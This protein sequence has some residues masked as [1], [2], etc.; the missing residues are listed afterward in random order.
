MQGR[1]RTRIVILTVMIALSAGPRAYAQLRLPQLPLPALPPRILPQPLDNLEQT[2]LTKVTELRRLR[3]RDLVRA[4]RDVVEINRD[5]D[6]VVRG[7]ILAL[8]SDASVLPRLQALGFSV[9]RRQPLAILD[10]EFIVL[11]VPPGWSTRKAIEKLRALDASG[12]F[13]YNHLYSGVG[14]DGPSAAAPS[15]PSVTP[16][17]APITDAP[18]RIGLLD[19]GI[20]TRHEA[21]R[22]SS[23]HA[24][25]CGG[26]SVP[27][28]HGTAVASILVGNSTVFHGVRPG[29]QLFA[30]DVYCGRPTGGAADVIVAAMAWMIQERVPVINVSLVGPRN[31]LL[32]IAVRRLI[33]RG[34]VVVA[35]VGNDGPAAP[36]L[37][38]AA[39]PHVVGVT[40]VDRRR[41]VLLEAG[42]GPQVMFAAPG[43][44]MSAAA[45][46]GGYAEVR[47]TSFAAPIVAALLAGCLKEPE[48]AAARDAVDALVRDALDLGA[49][50]KDFTYGNG[51]VGEAFWIDPHALPHR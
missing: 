27:D 51:L 1:P 44:Q 43:A 20:D 7:E 26:R 37:Y 41:H 33:Q 4:H 6:A 28:S 42:R 21:L 47:G 32:E 13:D 46:D 49:A 30:A 19:T 2:A 31:A 9:A 38:P 18:V 22:G 16:D 14:E 11:T 40:G 17:P 48:P 15:M 45:I 35:A 5:G 25:G 12:T 34:F 24:W 8:P 29:A 10:A 3:L 50:G 23:V 36:P 39:F